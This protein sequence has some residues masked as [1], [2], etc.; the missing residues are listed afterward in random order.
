MTYISD[1]YDLVLTY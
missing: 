1:K